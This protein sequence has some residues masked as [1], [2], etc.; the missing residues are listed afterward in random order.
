M[1]RSKKKKSKKFFLLSFTTDPLFFPYIVQYPTPPLETNVLVPPSLGR[2]PPLSPTLFYSKVSL[3]NNLLCIDCS[4]PYL[5][6]C[7]KSASTTMY[8]WQHCGQNDKKH[9]TCKTKKLECIMKQCT[10]AIRTNLHR[11]STYKHSRGPKK[12]HF[13]TNYANACKFAILP[14]TWPATNYGLVLPLAI[15]GRLA[16]AVCVCSTNTQ[17]WGLSSALQWVLSY[18]GPAVGPKPPS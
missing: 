11:I 7:M 10:R 14:A 17:R 8:E 9:T 1:K 6:A 16:L 18:Q 5:T 13:Q 2:R 4:L 12:G 15:W 3:I